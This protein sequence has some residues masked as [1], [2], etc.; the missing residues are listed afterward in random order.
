[1]GLSADDG[2]GPAVAPPEGTESRANAA[3]RVAEL[4]EGHSS[5]AGSLVESL[6]EDSPFGGS[7]EGGENCLNR[8]LQPLDP[9]SLPPALK[10]PAVDALASNPASHSSDCMEVD[11]KL[12]VAILGASWVGLP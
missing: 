1:M 8:G 6:L 3:D 4:H 12:D 5:H 7:A 10:M 11:V 9:S 2:L